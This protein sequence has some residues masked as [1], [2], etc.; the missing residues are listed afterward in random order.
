MQKTAKQKIIEQLKNLPNHYLMRKK[1]TGYYEQFLDQID[2]MEKA[3]YLDTERKI[4]SLCTK[5]QILKSFDMNKYLQGISELMLY[6]Y[7]CNNN[8]EFTPDKKMNQN[9]N[10]TDVDIQIIHKKCKYNIEIKSPVIDLT[11]QSKQ[12][13][14]VNMSYRTV[15]LEQ[16]N[17]SKVFLE[18]DIINKV[19]SNSKDQYKTFGYIKNEDTKLL[20]YLS[21][22]KDKFSPDEEDGLNILFLTLPSDK[23]QDYWSYLYNPYSGLFTDSFDLFGFYDEEGVQYKQSDFEKIDLI[24]LSN[25]ISGHLK[26]IEDFTT[27]NIE[28]YCNLLCIN[29]LGKKFKKNNNELL[30][31]FIQF[32]PHDT[33][34]FEEGLVLVQKK[35]EAMKADGPILESI[36]LQTFLYDHYN[37]LL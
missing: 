9:C 29:F 31:S 13:L 21:S 36:Y 14:K 8:F 37:R 26:T 24:I 28:N 35:E 4:K 20:S 22:C 30:N 34:R 3:G 23:M 16:L 6:I 11:E 17:L 15:P 25:V 5:L 1:N 19:V 12:N 27:W 18:N 32:F 7:A 10:G 33:V 2:L